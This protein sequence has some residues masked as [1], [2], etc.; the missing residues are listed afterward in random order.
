MLFEGRDAAGKGGAIKR[1]TEHLN[2]RGARVVALT[3]PTDA[4]AVAVVLPALRRP[5]AQRRR[6]R[7]VRPVLVQPRRRGAGDGLL[8]SDPVPRLHARD[9]RA[10][11]DARPLRHPPREA[12]VLRVPCR[13]GGPVRRTASDPVRRWKLSPTD[14]ASLDKWDDYTA[15]KETMFFHTDTGD[16]PWTVVKS[17]DKKRARLEAMRVL[18]S[19]LDYPSKDTR[20]VG[21]P[22]PLDRRPGRQ[23]PRGRRGPGAVLPL[24]RPVT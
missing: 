19:Q 2:P 15:A 16:A 5:P 9:P 8:Q 3:V 1:F 18:L 24:A 23:G 6:D 11:A 22:D 21:V 10:R 20:L 14:L 12:V 4:G 7:A 13:A 17:N